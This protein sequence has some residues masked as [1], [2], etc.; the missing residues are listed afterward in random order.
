[1]VTFLCNCYKFSARLFALGGKELLSHEGTT[2]LGPTAV[3][4]YGIALIL[5]TCYS[6]R[7][8]KMATFA[9]DLTSARR[10]SKLRS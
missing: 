6:E 5:V 10:L 1:M 7:D 3:S 9:D 4:V 8:P 2:Q